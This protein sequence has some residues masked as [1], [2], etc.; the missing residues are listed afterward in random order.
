MQTYQLMKLVMI[1]WDWASGKWL[2]CI[3]QIYTYT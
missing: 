2:P 3:I 1:D